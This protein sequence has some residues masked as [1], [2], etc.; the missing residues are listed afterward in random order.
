MRNIKY[1]IPKERIVTEEI[2]DL[3]FKDS[4]VKHGSS[5]IF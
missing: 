3:V 4:S 5:R 1:E 2:L